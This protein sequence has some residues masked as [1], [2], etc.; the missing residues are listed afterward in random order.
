MYTKKINFK[1]QYV[2]PYNKIIF[3][4]CLLCLCNSSINRCT[5]SV[6]KLVYMHTDLPRVV[7]ILVL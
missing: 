3:K 4:I 1:N 5:T 7:F 6:L 2:F